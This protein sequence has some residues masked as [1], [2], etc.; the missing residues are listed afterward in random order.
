MPSSCCHRYR[1]FPHVCSFVSLWDAGNLV[2]LNFKTSASVAREL[3]QNYQH[4]V[5]ATEKRCFIQA[6]FFF[7]TKLLCC[8]VAAPVLRY[9]PS[10]RV[11]CAEPELCRNNL[12]LYNFDQQPVLCV[13]CSVPKR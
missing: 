13:V 11:C 2:P 9:S 4:F 12:Q 5:A 1:T 6:K 10:V 7:N 3:L 8:V